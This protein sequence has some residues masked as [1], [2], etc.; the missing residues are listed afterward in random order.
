MT[1]RHHTAPVEAVTISLGMVEFEIAVNAGPRVL[2]FRRPGGPDLLARL[3]DAGIDVPALGRFRF[4][5]GHRLW[6]AP[7][8]PPITY[9]PDDV[10]VEIEQTDSSVAVTGAPDG[11][12]VV[13]RLVLTVT[14]EQVMVEHVLVNA[15]AQAVEV[16]PWAITQMAP[17]GT[18]YLPFG[19]GRDDGGV[20]PDRRLIVWPYT[21]LGAPELDLDGTMIS[22]H[23]SLRPAKL[24]VGT[25]N[26]RG[27]IAYH[28]NEELFVKWAPIHGEGASYA[29][30]GASIQCYRDERFL[31]L[32]TLGPLRTLAPGGTTVHTE[33]WQLLGVGDADVRSVLEQLPTTPEGAHP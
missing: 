24:K 12:G 31:E 1:T 8:I 21:D 11:D 22:I 17:G 19:S 28:L 7:E 5:G 14:G 13:K 10:A 15:G 18:A 16:A 25:E 3:G 27:W 23:A 26:T 2:G 4:L 9:Q 30:K 29:D 32:E 33:M 6:R 20:L